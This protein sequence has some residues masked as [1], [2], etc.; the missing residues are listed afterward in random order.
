MLLEW[1]FVGSAFEDSCVS[2]RLRVIR[3]SGGLTS[4]QKIYDLK[5]SKNPTIRISGISRMNLSQ[6]KFR[7]N[8][9]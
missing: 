9:L 8:H 2:F 1:S 5:L 7:D 3:C 6:K 4:S